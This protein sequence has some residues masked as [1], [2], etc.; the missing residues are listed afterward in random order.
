MEFFCKNN[1]FFDVLLC[2]VCM[3]WYNIVKLL[4][5]RG[6]YGTDKVSCMRKRDKF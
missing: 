3:R 2:T 6:L 1:L 4:Q 5:G